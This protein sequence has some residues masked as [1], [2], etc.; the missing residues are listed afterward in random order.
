MFNKLHAW[1]PSAVFP[2]FCIKIFS[3]FGF[4]VLYSTLFLFISNELGGSAEYASS[5]TGIFL[6]L[7]FVLHLLGG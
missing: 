5:L 2:F 4:A 3:T 6:A 7:N 1:M